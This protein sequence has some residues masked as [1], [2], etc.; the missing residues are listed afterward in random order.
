MDNFVYYELI[1]ETIKDESTS[2]I[3]VDSLLDDVDMYAHKKDAIL[4]EWEVAKSI[5]K[6]LL[7]LEKIY[8]KLEVL[9]VYTIEL[10]NFCE[11]LPEYKIK[12]LIDKNYYPMLTPDISINPPIDPIVMYELI[13]IPELDIRVTSKIRN[14]EYIIKTV[15]KYL[16]D[17]S[18]KLSCKLD[19]T[20][21]NTMILLLKNNNYRMKSKESNINILSQSN[22]KRDNKNNGIGY[23][24]MVAKWD[25]NAYLNNLTRI[26]E[27]NTNLLYTI[28]EFLEKN[29]ENKDLIEIHERFQLK[30]FWIDL[31]EKYEINEDKYIMSIKYILQIINHIGL[32]IKIPFFDLFKSEYQNT[33]MS[34]CTEIKTYIDQIQIQEK[35]DTINDN[36]YVN[37]LQPMQSDDYP[38]VEKNKQYFTKEVNEFVNF[39]KSGTP[40]IILNHFK[41][42]QKSLPITKD[43]AVFFRKDTNTMSVFKFLVIPNEDT[44]YKFG[45]FVFDVFLPKDFP[46]VCPIVNHTTSRKNNFR[47]NPN[48]YSCGKVC[49]SLLGTWG[50]QS[51]S[52]SWIPP[53]ADGTGSTLLQLILSIYSMIFTEHPWYNEPGRESGIKQATTNKT[54][55]DYNEEIRHGTIKYAILN[56]LKYPEEGFEN[57]IKAH[58][59]LKKDSIVKYLSEVDGGKYVDQFKKLVN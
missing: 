41:M 6:E 39:T 45:C 38:Y 56:Q 14:I 46:N 11:K 28:C 36:E 33:S 17:N 23:G 9:S 42:I 18:D 26:K 1:G 53:N 54:S 58:F 3:N 30:Q 55:L 34:V 4:S 40:R 49:L 10:N 20:I 51:Q 15:S 2:K 19:Y 5:I 47:F 8:K 43:S 31:L 50:G 44:P 7:K 32:K 21:T 22:D 24:G 37:I 25:V 27:T 16:Q 48:L 12:L 57:V 35:K 29:S 59:K 13:S 52:E